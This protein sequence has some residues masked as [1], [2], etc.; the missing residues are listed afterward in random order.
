MFKTMKLGTKI[1]AGFTVL[2]MIALALGGLAVWNMNS[3]KAVANVLANENVPEVAVANE[4]ERY[5]MMTM[6]MARGY[7][8]S[9]ETHFLDDAHKNLAQI[10]K[11]LQ[12]A[13]EHAAKYEM[14][15]F[16]LNADK[17]DA[18]AQEYE[19][20]LG[21][22][23]ARIDAMA[24]DRATMIET[25]VKY[26]KVC[27]EFV[28]GQ[29]A[30]LKEQVKTIKTEPNVD[31]EAAILDRVRTIG[32]V[33]DVIDLGNAVR[34]GNWKAQAL[35]DAKLY[36]ETMK[37]FEQITAKLDEL[38]SITKEEVNFKQIEECRAAGNAYHEAMISYLANWTAR[39]DIG[40]K[41]G[42]VAQA[43]L[44]AAK[45]ASGL[46][47]GDTAKASEA[48]AG[49]LSV[50]SM[51][52]IVGLS[53]AVVVGVLL[54]IFITRSI[55]GPI[56]RIIGGLA[57]G[58]E[59]TISAANQVS[60]ASQSLA[61]GASEQAAA[62]EE[63][64]SS[65]E[66]MASMTKQN[67]SNAVE[68]KNLAGR[69]KSDADKG[70]EA[71]VRMSKAIDDIKKSSDDTAKI[72]KTIDEIAFQ[73]NLLALN[74]AVE[75]ARAGE[76]GKGFAVVA[77]EVR[78]LAQRSAEAAKNTS[79]LIE[80]SVKNADN[81]VGNSKE[82][83]E[84]LKEIAEGNRKVNDLV[85]EIAAASNEQS[86]G[87]EQINTAVGQ[88]D[89]VTQ[90]NAANAEES[91]SASEELSAQAEELNKMVRD[92]RALVGGAAASNDDAARSTASAHGYQASEAGKAPAKAPKAAKGAPASKA[93]LRKVQE[94]AEALPLDGGDELSKF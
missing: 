78:N 35:R 46:G 22:T 10:K 79:S 54:A 3:V 81:G 66:E 36:A 17:A 20:L 89:S 34:M 75:A 15:A 23:V 57:S 27:N 5:A 61:Q 21:D 30:K 90:Q 26:M 71:M 94:A 16:K 11:N 80:G 25:A 29:E 62:I 91:A 73:T 58:S 12:Q 83:G 39:E 19:K 45:D 77:E 93:A 70:A 2:I 8:Y 88:M 92:L 53:I 42:E 64:T 28:D 72:V 33:N 63:T 4:V 59:Q 1:A 86:Q 84:A 50:A 24:K 9:E 31:H 69:A 37:T 76:A 48:A 65:V 41:R 74:A 87:I 38:K 6:Y 85:G 40:K 68:A 13:K 43:V 52:M 14:A 82:V 67:A 56:N 55:T 32:L 47:M 60:S 7:I 18:K 44:D 49:S 51:T